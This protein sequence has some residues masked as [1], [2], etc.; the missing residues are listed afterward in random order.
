MINVPEE[1]QEKICNCH[2]KW[3]HFQIVDRFQ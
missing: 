2:L 1:T 3:I